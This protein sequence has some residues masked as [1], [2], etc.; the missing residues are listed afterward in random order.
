MAYVSNSGLARRG[1][2]RRP[3][4][5]PHERDLPIRIVDSNRGGTANDDWTYMRFDVAES[6]APS[7]ANQQIML[8]QKL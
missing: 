1:S 3:R 6:T 4:E 7:F 8:N 2:Y 5:A